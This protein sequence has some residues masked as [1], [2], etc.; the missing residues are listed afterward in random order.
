ME[1]THISEIQKEIQNEFTRINNN[2]LTLH[3]KTSVALFVFSFFVEL[4]IGYIMANSDQLSTTIPKFIFKFIIVPVTLNLV[5]ILIDFFVMRSSSISQDKKVYII[6]LLF[7]VMCFVLFTV[8]IAFSALYFMFSLPVFLTIIYANYVLTGITSM[9]SMIAMIFSELFIKWDIDKVSIYKD[10]NRFGDFLLSIF[11]LLAFSAASMVVIRFEREKNTASIQKEMERFQLQKKIQMDEL[12]GIN[13]RRA[14]HDAFKDMETDTTNSTYIF[15][16]LDIDNFKTLNDTYGHIIGDKCLIHMG[17]ILLKNCK[18]GVPFRYGGDEFC[19]LF[20]NYTMEY[21]VE[22]CEQIRSDL[23]SIKF[24]HLEDLKLTTS[25]GISGYAKYMD[26]ARL[27]INS[28][29]A[30]Y[31]AKAIKNTIH[32]YNKSIS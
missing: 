27:I 13:N 31:S 24:E 26:A 14:L 20:R 10:T 8:H 32:I 15:V 9:L 23:Q 5:C 2:W 18:D 25:M 3:Y 4:L 11:I 1:K 7:I 29:Q 19:I 16:M 6:S 17:E 30:L 28:D 22:I 12:T 21:V